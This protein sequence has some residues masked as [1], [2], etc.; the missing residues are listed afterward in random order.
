MIQ[1]SIDWVTENAPYDGVMLDLETLGTG[2]NSVII[3]IGAV[4]FN[5]EQQSLGDSFYAV[6]NQESCQDIGCTTDPDT[7][8]WW[9]KQSP[10]ARTVLSTPGSDV[11]PVLES[12][13]GWLHMNDEVWGNGSDFDNAMLAE[14]YRKAM[15]DLPWKFWNNRCYRTMKNMFPRV[16]FMRQGTHHNALDD[17]KS[18]AVHLMR[19]L[20]RI[21]TKQLAA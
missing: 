7:L 12:L 13:A 6:I 14:L 17:A 18:Q 19:I 4:K 21:Q 2:A 20:E 3:A 9:D 1:I 10:E 11:V 5:V 16:T 15:I 8:I